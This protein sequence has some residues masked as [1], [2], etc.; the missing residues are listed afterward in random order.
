MRESEPLRRAFYEAW[1]TRA[2]DQGPAAGRW[3]NAP[4]MEDILRRRHEAARLLDFGNYAEYALATRMAHSVEE[5]LTFLHELAAR[6]ARRGA[7]A[8]SPS[9]RPSPA[10]RWPP[11]TWASTPS[12]CSASRFSVSQEELRPY[13][14]LPRVLG[15][16]VRGRRA[17]VRRR[18]SASAA[19]SPVWHP[20]VRYFEISDAAGERDRQ[21]LPRR[22]RARR[23]SAAAPGWTSASAASA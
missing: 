17:P 2:S 6:G 19:A 23:T 1:T 9:S 7:C 14:P 16:P 20:D 22:L 15:G 21:L 10:A 5:V 3:D 13:F 18:A 4:V 12:G 8:S 11:G